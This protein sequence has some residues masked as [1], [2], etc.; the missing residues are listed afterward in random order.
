MAPLFTGLKL[1]F[2]LGVEA[3]FPGFIDASYP[4]G[5]AITSDNF[6]IVTYTSSG[7]FVVN[8]TGGPTAETIELLVVAGGG[9]GGGAAAGPTYGFG[10]GAGG[11][12]YFS[13]QPVTAQSYPVTVGTGGPGK[14][15]PGGAGT[16]G[17][18]SS[19]GPISATGGGGGKSSGGTGPNPGGSGGGGFLSNGNAGAYTPVEGYPGT[20][21]QTDNPAIGGMGGGGGAGGIGGPGQDLRYSP[22]GG[23]GVTNS[24]SGSSVTY[25]PGGGGGGSAFATASGEPRT[26]NNY[27]AG[28][29]GAGYDEGINTIGGAGRAG[30]VIVKYKYQ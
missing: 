19:F 26:P 25:S 6:R 17:N 28:G 18:P 8:S 27:G 30:V 7:A 22:S 15:G 4:G 10:G 16:A 13:T 12:R 1:G 23:A 24:I 21:E 3:S 2:G 14:N 20:N 29:A 9:G 5:S 11:Y